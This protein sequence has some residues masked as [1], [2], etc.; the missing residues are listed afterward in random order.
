[1]IKGVL[2]IAL[3][4]LLV[5]PIVSYGE[6]KEKKCEEKCLSLCSDKDDKSHADCM[7]YCMNQCMRDRLTANYNLSPKQKSGLDSTKPCAETET[8]TVNIMVASVRRNRFAY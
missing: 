3:A 6:T 2:L 1:M 4:T 8:A 7:T 5:S